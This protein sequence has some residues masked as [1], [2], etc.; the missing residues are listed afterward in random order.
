[1]LVKR[2]G[3]VSRVFQ[4]LGIVVTLAACCIN[5]WRKREVYGKDKQFG[6]LYF[7]SLCSW[8]V[9]FVNILE[10][11]KFYNSQLDEYC[12]CCGPLQGRWMLGWRYWITYALPFLL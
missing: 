9:K 7:R 5:T 1:M 4:Y 8:N 11:A 3:V 6:S 2:R 12:T 10:F